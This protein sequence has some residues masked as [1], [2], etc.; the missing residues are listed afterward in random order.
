MNDHQKDLELKQ[1][2]EKAQLPKDIA[3]RLQKLESIDS[4]L[5]R[6][7]GGR[8]RSLVRLFSTKSLLLTSVS[9]LLAFSA[10]YLTRQNLV[11]SGDFR[12]RLTKKTVPVVGDSVKNKPVLP[13]LVA[14]RYYADWCPRCPKTAPIYKDLLDKYGDSPLMIL[15][16]DVTSKNNSCQS[17]Q[18]MKLLNIEWIENHNLETGSILLIDRKKNEILAVVKRMSERLNFEAALTDSLVHMK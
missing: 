13:R 5:T 14:V 12:S 6:S 2:Y 9:V 11:H 8:M 3:E 7:T 16:L 4:N 10:G 18:L 17:R 1:F 15:T